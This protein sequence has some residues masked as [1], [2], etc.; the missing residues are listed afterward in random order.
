MSIKPARPRHEP[1]TPCH[2]AHAQLPVWIVR[3]L[4]AGVGTH[5]HAVSG[6][7]ALVCVCMW[8]CWM[9]FGR[10]LFINEFMFR[11]CSGYKY[12]LYQWLCDTERIL[13]ALW[14]LQRVTRDLA[15]VGRRGG[16]RA[17]GQA[18][19]RHN[20]LGSPSCFLLSV[21]LCVCKKQTKTERNW[22]T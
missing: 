11:E 21:Y 6:T 13:P 5:C 2:A 12:P 17:G 10:Q 19:W 9:V 3:C 8:R 20:M 15:L 18:V 22:P 4:C 1:V 16:G 14:H 7:A